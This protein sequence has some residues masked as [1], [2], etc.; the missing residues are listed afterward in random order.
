MLLRLSSILLPMGLLLGACQNDVNN[1]PSKVE[2]LKKDLI[3]RWE[4]TKGFRNNKE[5]E[6][7]T[8]TYYEFTDDKMS[9]N[10]TP[11][12]DP[13]FDYSFEDNIIEQKG[14][15]VF[16]YKVDTLTADLLTLSTVI[17]NFPFRLELKKVVPSNEPA[18]SDTTKDAEF[19]EL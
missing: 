3:G 4:L 5:T 8:G 1:A 19:K 9:T 14:E 6:T 15:S 7:L 17:N 11:S 13:S 18:A 16:V 12:L 10:L 2:Y